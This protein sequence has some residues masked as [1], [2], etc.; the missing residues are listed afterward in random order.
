MQEGYFILVESFVMDLPTRGVF[1][2]TRKCSLSQTKLWCRYAL[3]LVASEMAWDSPWTLHHSEEISFSVKREK[4]CVTNIPLAV[5]PRLPVWWAKSISRALIYESTLSG[6]IR[7]I[8]I[9]ETTKPMTHFELIK[10]RKNYLRK[11]NKKRVFYNVGTT[12]SLSGKYSSSQ[13]SYVCL[14]ANPTKQLHQ[15]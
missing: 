13:S 11:E 6:S 9:F 8:I 14:Y 4:F 3:F 7:K 5:F 15:T 12:V 10:H 1:S 2:Y